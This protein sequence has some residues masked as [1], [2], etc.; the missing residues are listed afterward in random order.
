MSRGNSS[1][2]RDGTIAKGLVISA[3]AADIMAGA[4][5]VLERC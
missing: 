2:G 1:Q 3:V 5:S 4:G